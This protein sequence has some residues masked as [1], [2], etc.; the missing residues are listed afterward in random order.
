MPNAS[1]IVADLARDQQEAVANNSARLLILAGAGSGKTRV[2]THR[3][4]WLIYQKGVS[5]ENV[6]LLTFTNKAAEE[7]K[8]RVTKLL[9]CQATDTPVAI[10]PWAGTFHS[11]CSR[12]LRESGRSVGISP[13]FAIY[14]EA[15]QLELVKDII[16]VLGLEKSIRPTSVLAV[17]S[18]AKNE[19]IDHIEY[20]RYV[21][22]EWQK[23]VAQIYLEYQKALQENNALDFDDLLVYTVKLFTQDKGALV[24][25]Q[26]RFPYIL[27]DEWQDTN[28]AQY[29]IIKLLV[30]EAGNLT[31]VGDAAQSIYAW[32]GANHRNITYLMQDFPDLAVANLEQNYRSTQN[33]LNVAYHVINKNT[34]HPILKLWTKNSTGEPVKIYQAGSELD[35]AWFV[36]SKTKELVQQGYS[37]SDIAILYRM[38]AQSR[39]LEEALLHE[40]IPY[41]IVGGVRFYDRREI[42][43]VLSY[44]RLVANPKDTVSAKRVEKLGKKRLE[45]FQAVVASPDSRKASTLEVLD[46]VLQVTDYLSL[47]DPAN[48]DDQARLENIKELRSVATAFTNLDEFLEQVA[49]IETAQTPRGGLARTSNGAMTLMTAHA[50]K[51]L[52]FAAVFIV[53]LEEG[54][55]PHSRSLENLEKLEEE[56]R[57]AYVGIT[58]AKKLLYLTHACRRMIF[59]RSGGSIPSRFLADIPEHLVEGIYFLENDF[60]F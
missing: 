49:L 1:P 8:V 56:R 33:I 10:H 14:A 41:I 20:A 48:I 13:R 21:Q 59:G 42:K 3:A 19:L 44:L 58:R 30:G 5:A 32:R 28:R 4:A 2:L 15:D 6:L 11:F 24:N 36:A 27:V 34:T 25:Y 40:S 47:Y 45:K 52:E 26:D 39:T 57:L 37:Y 35:E 16:K 23:K 31:V 51:G 12:V 54:I 55:F 60:E 9:T 29:Q 22:D 50:A 43:D 18:G 46:R 7:M 17:I 38:N 53:G